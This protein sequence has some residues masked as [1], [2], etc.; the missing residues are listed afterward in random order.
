MLEHLK[1]RAEKMPS[2]GKIARP[3]KKQQ[4]SIKA[5][6]NKLKFHLE[7]FV[8]YIN[9][10]RYEQSKDKTVKISTK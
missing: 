3:P 2:V 8:I 9:S 10:T 5:A 6:A 7:Y 4:G 1:D